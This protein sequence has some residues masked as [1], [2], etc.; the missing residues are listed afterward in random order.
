[1]AGIDFAKLSGPPAADRETHPRAI[2]AA[3][4][5]K[6]SRFEYL[7]D[8]QR[9]VFD[10]WYA[11]RNKPDLVV[12]MNTGNGKTVVGLLLLKSSLNEGLGPAAYLT[13]DTYLAE[14]VL[15]TA[16]DLGLAVSNDPRDS[17]VLQGQAI[18]VATVHTLFNG[19]SKFGVGTEGRK[20]RLGSVL[21]DDAHA[22]LSAVEQ[23]FEL[24]IP[25]THPAYKKLRDIVDASLSQQYPVGV[26]DLRDGDTTA[27]LMVPP[28]N[29]FDLGPGVTSI[30]HD[31]RDD[32]E[33]QWSWP[34]IKNVVPLSRCVVST[35]EVQVK[36]PLPPIEQIPSFVQAKRRIYLTATLADDSVLVT[37]FGANA[38]SVVKP[39]TPSTADDI[40]ERMI[41]VP[42]EF[43]PEWTEDSIK[44][45]LVELSTRTNVVVIVP[46][47]RR[48]KWWEHNAKAVL[49]IANLQAGISTLKDSKSGLTVL[50]GKYDGVDLPDDACRVLVIDGLP[51]AY[52]GMDRVESA[53]LEDT[54][55]MSGRQLQRIEQGMGRGIRSRNDYAVVMLMGTKL[56]RRLHDPAAMQYFSP[57]TRVQLAFSQLIIKQLKSGTV[58]DFKDVVDQCLHRDQGW[59]D[60]SRNALIGVTYGDGTVSPT[61]QPR[62]RAFDLASQQRY[63][64]AADAE[65]Q[66]INALAADVQ[67]RGWLRQ[68]KAAYLHPIN[69]L[70]AQNL[71]VNALDDNRS[72]L[73]PNQGV[74]YVRLKGKAG[75]QAAEAAS[76]LSSRYGSPGDL[77][78]GINGI[79]AD[80]TF[81]PAPTTVEPFEQALAD[82]GEHLGFASQRPEKNFRRGPDVLWQ[83]GST[84]YAV[85][86]AK[87]NVVT[88]FIRKHDAGQLSV[89]VSWFEDQ[90]DQPSTA[91]PVMLHRS[92]KPAYDAFVPQ[93]TRIVTTGGMERLKTA[94]RAWGTALASDGSFDNPDRMGQ[95]LAQHKLNG[96]QALLNYAIGA[97]A[98]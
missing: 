77:L 70:A 16:K 71:Q 90:Y 21:V 78:I 79:L 35:D 64:E 24:R 76:F 73:K 28:W 97:N 93:G 65:Q 29:W 81:D 33:L 39:I 80:L 22:C 92:N 85:I 68:Q 50:I 18:L 91:I 30:L 75:D 45:Y 11:E 57:A 42:Q 40:G 6:I 27:A 3:L 87:N 63:Q 44:E 25:A 82:L 37:H 2:W 4:S 19:R 69:P 1:M 12:K 38:D 23:Q 36:P 43:R 86:E 9:E 56:V 17:A 32:D 98:I 72:L 61:A 8:V 55:A 49:S 7:R 88:D 31:H 66:A 74:T 54:W 5:S 48:S 59:V 58:Q 60:A 51:E 84:E 26:L 34:L 83:L 14:Q 62:R 96:R 94:V 15:G 20:I 13:P 47:A 10:K 52:S 41:L 67:T 53:A 95:Q 89:S 46:S